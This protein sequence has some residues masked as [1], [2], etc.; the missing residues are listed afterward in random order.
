MKNAF[1]FLC[2]FFLLPAPAA[3]SAQGR[4][5]VEDG[6]PGAPKGCLSVA[7]LELTAEQRAAVRKIESE[8]GERNSEL[9]SRMMAKR[10]ELEHAFRDPGSDEKMIRAKAA[11]LADIQNQCRQATL[12]HRLAVRALLSPEQLRVW[13]ASTEPCRMRRR[14]RPW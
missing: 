1:F 9:Q 14:G 13:C 3:V 4:C 11:E 5:Q 8:Y 7:G 2:L 6:V 10:L 12:D